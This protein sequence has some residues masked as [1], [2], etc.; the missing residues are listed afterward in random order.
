MEKQDLRKFFLKRRDKLSKEEVYSASL[1]IMD[2]VS[3]DSYFIQSKSVMIYMPIRNEADPFVNIDIYKDKILSVPKTYKED[4]MPCLYKEPLKVSKYGIKE[5]VGCEEIN[6]DLCLVPGVCFD[7]HLYRIGFGKGYYDR[8]LKKHKSVYS[9]GIC[10]DFQIVDDIEPET[11]DVRLNK[12]ISENYV[13]EG[14]YR[15]NLSL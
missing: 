10:Y 4:I 12:I 2:N 13:I 11:H 5:P 6:I 9:I 15:W 7:K 1:K 8:F 14:G 3:K